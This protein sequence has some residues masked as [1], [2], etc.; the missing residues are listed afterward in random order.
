M[1]ARWA[2]PLMSPFQLKAMNRLY[3]LIL[4]LSISKVTLS[5][6]SLT[7]YT[8]SK[9][10]LKRQPPIYYRFSEETDSSKVNFNYTK[11]YELSI[12]TCNL[13]S[14]EFYYSFFFLDGKIKFC[15]YFIFKNPHKNR[16]RN[17]YK[18]W[19]QDDKFYGQKSYNFTNETYSLLLKKGYELYQ[20]GIEFLK[21]KR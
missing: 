11:N 19:L 10:C 13:K 9:E 2:K 12:V 20:A 6:N 18:F 3:F 17:V 5:Q 21:T 4:L 8:I 1:H 14:G 16:E 7:Y 15:S